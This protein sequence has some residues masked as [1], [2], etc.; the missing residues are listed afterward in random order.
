[1]L[2]WTHGGS[3]SKG[4]TPGCNLQKPIRLTA[5]QAFLFRAESD[6]LTAHFATSMRERSELAQVYAA[7]TYRNWQVFASTGP[8]GPQLGALSHPS[9]V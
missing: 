3:F 6:V 2:F 5:S 4:V 1:M 8:L 9:F 7:G